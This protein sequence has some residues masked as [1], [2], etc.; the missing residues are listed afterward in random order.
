MLGR[1]WF[2][3]G[4]QIAYYYA[5]NITCIV[6]KHMAMRFVSVCVEQN[7]LATYLEVIKNN[8]CFENADSLTL[9]L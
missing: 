1:K 7:A 2:A 6:C 5:D 9:M 3:H 4:S 8:G